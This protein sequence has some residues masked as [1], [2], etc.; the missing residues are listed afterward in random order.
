MPQSRHSDGGGHRSDTKGNDFAI[1]ALK[2][3]LTLSS[4][5]LALTITFLKDVLG[6]ARTQ[7]S[8]QWLLPIAWALLLVVIWTA[9]VAMADAAG[10]RLFVPVHHQTFQLSRESY[11]E[12]IERVQT[13]LMH[14]EDRLGVQAIG[15]TVVLA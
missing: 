5:I 1:D 7:A 15:Q 10:A 2:Q 11:M 14:E 12:P 8:W 13:A 4:I 6:D 3:L 9:W